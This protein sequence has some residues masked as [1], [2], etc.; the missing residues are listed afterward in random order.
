MIRL[1]DIAWPLA[2]FALLALGG[3]FAIWQ[4]RALEL[5]APEDAPTVL[6]PELFQAARPLEPMLDLDPERVALGRLLFSDTR[7]SADRTMAC[8]SCHDLGRGGVDGRQFSIGIGGAVGGINAPSV[9]NSGYGFVQFWDGRAQTLEEQAAG[10][11]HNPIEMGSNWVQVLE[12][13]RADPALVAA[14]ERSYPDGLDAASVVDAIAS[15]ERSLVTLDSRFDRYLRGDASALDAREI[16]GYRHFRELGCTSCHQG[17]LLGGNMYQKFGVLGD[18]FAGRGTTQADLG[19]YNVTG[20][21]EDRHVFKVPGLR[22]VALT[23]PYFHDGS[24]T[25]LEQAVT[26]M[27]RYQL[28]RTLSS[29]E[30][31]AIAAFLRALTGQLP[32][33]EAP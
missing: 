21:E 25:T 29:A 4:G 15:F 11:I 3:G 27:A 7:L 17:I 24:A 13:L 31:E 22:N 19:R 12:R 6:H 32:A 10:P 26:V 9:L 30:T 33:G 14:F 16:E 28:G 18:Y 23:A 5:P 20:R 8:V 1:R 2:L